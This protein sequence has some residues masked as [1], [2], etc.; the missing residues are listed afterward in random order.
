MS[1]NLLKILKSIRAENMCHFLLLPYPHLSCGEGKKTK[2]IHCIFHIGAKL[3]LMIG[4]KAFVDFIITGVPMLSFSGFYLYKMCMM[5]K[6][7]KNI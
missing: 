5:R 7:H 1:S 6:F 4:K 2:K 3:L